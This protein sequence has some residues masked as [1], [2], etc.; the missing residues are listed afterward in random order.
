[1]RQFP[2]IPPRFPQG[3]EAPATAART[4]GIRR[5]NASPRKL[6]SEKKQK[7]QKEQNP[8]DSPGTNSLAQQEDGNVGKHQSKNSSNMEAAKPTANEATV[9]WNDEWV[10]FLLESGSMIALNQYMD[11]ILGVDDSQVPSDYD[12]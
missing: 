10:D 8:I 5:R 4:M 12:A 11:T 2:W 7:Q 1:M 9:H 6:E 3:K